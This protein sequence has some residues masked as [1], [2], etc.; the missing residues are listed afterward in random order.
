MTTLPPRDAADSLDLLAM[1]HYA[2]AALWALVSLIPAS[3]VF[4]AHE[5]AGAS[6]LH[7]PGQPPPL[8]PSALAVA[9]ALAVI[10]VSFLGAALAVWGGRCLA[11][12]RR[13]RVAL[14][15]AVVLCLFVPIGTLLGAVTWTVLQRPQVRARFT[16]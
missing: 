9:L 15:A 3:W 16:G 5:L 2:V 8:P 1:A 6:G 4:V 13:Y 7:P 11:A 14:A 12:R 10:G